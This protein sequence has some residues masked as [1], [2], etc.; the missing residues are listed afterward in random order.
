MHQVVVQSQQ[1][2][3]A[4]LDIWREVFIVE[5]EVP[6]ELEVDEYDVL[7]TDITH[8]LVY[9]DQHH[10]VATARLMPYEQGSVKVQRVAVLRS[11]RGQGYGAA[12]MR[13]L[14]ELATKQNYQQVVLDAQCHA[15]D[16]YKKLGYAVVSDKF[17][18][19][20]IEH[21]RMRKPLK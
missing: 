3:D 10:P 5:Q 11:V 2:L 18:E 14:E 8:V 20:G 17:M 19:A 6:E 7:G 21:V 1:E 4:C 9:D 12:I 15:E 16:F 13:V